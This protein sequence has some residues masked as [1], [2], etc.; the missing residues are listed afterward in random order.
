MSLNDYRDQCGEAAAANGWHRDYEHAV[1]A[2][3]ILGP[4]FQQALTDHI[5]AKTALIGCEVAEA[6]EEIRDGHAP[7]E[8]YSGEGGKPEGYPTELADIIIRALDLAYMLGIDINTAVQNKLSFNA[9]RGEMHGGKK[10]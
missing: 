9:G 1:Q 6:I 2:R 8:T 5:V 10:L 4:E 7:G 3:K